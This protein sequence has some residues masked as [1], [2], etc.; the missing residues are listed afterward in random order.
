[1]GLHNLT[2]TLIGGYDFNDDGVPDVL[3][4]HNEQH[5]FDTSGNLLSRTL[6][7]DS[8]GNGVADLIYTDLHEY[9]RQ[10]NLLRTVSSVMDGYGTV[11]ASCLLTQAYD[12]R[13]NLRQRIETSDSNADGVTDSLVTTVWTTNI[14]AGNR[15]KS[16]H[17]L[18]HHCSDRRLDLFFAAWQEFHRGH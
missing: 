5:S 1:M 10:N 4:I 7:T 6:S 8:D 18:T 17:F 16:H 3:G 13:G 11:Y 14:V 9:D 15:K 2:Q 12:N